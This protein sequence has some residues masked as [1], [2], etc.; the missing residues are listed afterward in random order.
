M[1]PLD[2]QDFY[3]L[4]GLEPSASEKEIKRAYRYALMMETLTLMSK[5]VDF[6]LGQGGLESLRGRA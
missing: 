5:W 6:G 4:L 1:S 3:E 2:Y